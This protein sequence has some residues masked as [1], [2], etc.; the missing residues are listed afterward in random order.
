LTA[1]AAHGGLLRARRKLKAALHR[2]RAVLTAAAALLQYLPR[3][4]AELISFIV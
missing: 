2:C 4:K 1:A 3:S